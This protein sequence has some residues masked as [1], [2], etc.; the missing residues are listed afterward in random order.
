MRRLE[1]ITGRGSVIGDHIV[2]H[3]AVDFINL[4]GS[5]PVGAKHGRFIAMRPIMLELG[6]KDAAIVLEDADLDLTALKTLLLVP[7]TIQVNVV[8][9]SNVSL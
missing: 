2:E 5:T 6:G 3:K 9:P 8:Q 7:L 4:T 1:L